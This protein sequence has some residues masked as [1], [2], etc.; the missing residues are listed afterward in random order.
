[1]KKFSMSMMILIFAMTIALVGTGS[2]G[3]FGPDKA[4]TKKSGATTEQAMPAGK[5]LTLSGTIDANSRF[6]N[7]TGEVFA[8]ADNEKSKEVK[9]LQGQKVEIKGTVMEKAGKKTVEV[10]EYNILEN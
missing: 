3:I 9:S 6:I 5:Q 2:A 7:N 4:E 10:I 8:L 1:M